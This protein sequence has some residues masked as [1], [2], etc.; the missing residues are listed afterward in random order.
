MTSAERQFYLLIDNLQDY[1]LFLTDPERKVTTWNVGAERMTGWTEAEMIGQPAD[2]IFTPEDRVAGAPIQETDTAR[3]AGRAEDERWHLRKDGSRFWGSGLMTAL[4]DERGDLQGFCKIFRDLTQRM[5]WEERL[6]R[7]A[8][9]VELAYDAILVTNP[10]NVILLWNRAAEE[11]YGWSE[12]EAIGSS[13]TELLDTQF[14][15]SFEEAR[16]ALEATGRWVGE[17]THTC[18]SGEKIVV[19]S[20]WALQRD[21]HGFPVAVL[22]VNRDLTERKQAEKAQAA[23]YERERLINEIG[24]TIRSTLDPLEIQARAVEALGAA[25][26]ADRCLFAFIDT[27]HDQLEIAHDWRRAD[28]WSLASEYR[29]SDFAVDVQGLFV[30]GQTLVVEDALRGPWPEQTAVTLAQLQVRSLLGVPFYDDERLVA[31]LVV[32]MAE[33]PRAWTAD[34]V[35]LVEAIAT[36]TRNTVEAARVLEREQKIAQ[37]LQAALQPPL[38]PA[39]PGLRLQEYYRAALKE[40]QVGGDFYD[41]FPIEQHCSALV[42]G[43]VSGKGLTAAAQVATVRNM[44]RFALYEGHT[45]ADAVHRLNRVLVAKN[46]LEGFATLFIGTY[47]HNTGELNYVSCG[48]EPALLWRAETGA[49]EELL[50]TGTLLGVLPEAEFDQ[51][52]TMLALGDVLAIFTDGLTDAGP[53]RTSP[54]GMEGVAQLL[55]EHPRGETSASLVSRLMAAV[56]AYSQGVLQDDICLLVGIRE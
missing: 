7:K 48:Q 28:L 55:R 33:A 32:A 51:S 37:Q 15:V 18:R 47:D 13:A 1:S 26:H 30:P 12:A 8:G 20:R 19:E 49:V 44:L 6:Q 45:I 31:V 42:V 46:L 25:L 24:R 35:A 22:K 53:S 52:V 5:E 36:E 38:L 23:A 43:D 14:P 27:T 16:T 21:E 3:R 41:V 9:L 56:D 54:L 2:L 34:E 40:A 4:R 50:P 11:L 29:L 39:A 17:L 10:S